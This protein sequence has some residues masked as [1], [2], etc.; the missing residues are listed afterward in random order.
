ML[1]ATRYHSMVALYRLAAKSG[2][3]RPSSLAWNDVPLVYHWLGAYDF[4]TGLFRDLILYAVAC[5]MPLL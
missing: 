1:R 5:E 4:L 2:P 3:C